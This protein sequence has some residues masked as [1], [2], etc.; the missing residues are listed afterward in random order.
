MAFRL[1]RR[2]RIAP[3]VTLNLTKRG[4]S[5]SLGPRGAKMTLG[6]R[7]TRLTGGLPGTGMFYTKKL[8]G[9]TG[10]SRASRSSTQRSAPPP[11]PAEKLTLGFFRR[12][13]TPKDEVAFVDGMRE[14][15]AGH[16]KVALRHFARATNIPDA[17]YMAGMISLKFAQYQ[18]SKRH[19]T[20]ALAK[21][22]F[23]GHHL[24]K[25]GV[26][27]TIHLPVTPELQAVV[28]PNVRGVL[29]GLVEVHQRLEEWNDAIVRLEHLRRLEPD[30]TVVK[31]SLAELLL[32]AAPGDKHAAHRIVRLTEGIE[33]DTAI[34]TALLL[35]KAQALRTLELP[36]AARDCLTTGLRRTRNRPEELL[37]A[38]R[39]ERAQVYEDL[40]QAA[41]ARSEFGKI[42]A[43]APDYE[44]VA[45]RL[46]AAS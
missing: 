19:L 30:D 43:E 45:Q 34:E 32:D 29:L 33:N 39:Y 15:A 23:L 7:G 4:V 12:L 24:H 42:Y 40:G 25:Y 14:A 38:L 41:R 36:K 22:R 1:F 28:G 37:R 11:P 31:L 16:P 20:A 26:E 35:Y 6:R 3:G 17:C 8:G 5:A 44:D 18:D 46:G 10:R 27:A 21:A 13:M 9:K 2:I